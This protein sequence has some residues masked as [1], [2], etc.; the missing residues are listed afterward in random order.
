MPLGLV[1]AL[2]LALVTFIYV[3]SVSRPTVK[4]EQRPRRDVLGTVSS[5]AVAT[6]PCPMAW[7]LAHRLW[8]PVAHR[9]YQASRFAARLATSADGLAPVG[10][11]LGRAS[12]SCVGAPGRVSGGTL[13]GLAG[14]SPHSSIS[15]GPSASPSMRVHP[16]GDKW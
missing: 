10:V 1:A 5:D 12:R 4:A 3:G 11:P 16:N 2:N 15:P 13:V 6:S 9:S 7:S 8:I 14:F